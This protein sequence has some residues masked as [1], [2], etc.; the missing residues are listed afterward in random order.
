[1]FV[2][3]LYLAETVDE[4]IY[5]LLYDR[6]DFVHESIGMFE[7]IL[8]KNMLDFQKDIISGD[9]TPQQLEN[10]SREISMAIKKSKLQ[11]SQFE[12]QRNE[13][14][15]EGEFRKLINGLE[16]NN[17]FLKPSDAARL[18]ES[19]LIKNDSTYKSIDEESGCLT[20]SSKIMKELERFTRL[21]GMEGSTAELHSLLTA[22]GPIEVIFNGSTAGDGGAQF[23]PPTGFWIKFI[24]Q[25]LEQENN[26]L[27]TFSFSTKESNSFLN[28]GCYIILIFEIE[29]EGIKVEHHLAMV[30]INM[31]SMQVFEGN[32]V[33]TARQFTKS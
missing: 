27:R 11:Y 15:G 8:S 30:P 22:N 19:F 23:L 17:D 31:E 16:Q 6:I 21:P 13:L 33:E 12:E 9:L 32:Y 28:S 1:V 3:S 24:L 5:E 14:L 4:R 25:R 29:V 26:I 10:R 20:L 18:T 2:A 7:P